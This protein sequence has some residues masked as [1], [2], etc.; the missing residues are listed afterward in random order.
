MTGIGLVLSGGGARGAYEVGVL[1]HI[2]DALPE[3][4]GRIRVITGASVGAVNAAFLASRGMT[5]AA[6]HELAAFWSRLSVDALI[7]LDRAG[8][9]SLVAA[10]GKRLIGREVDSPPVGLLNV[11][12]IANLVAE[13]TDWRNLRKVVRSRK[14][15]AVGVTAT[16]IS[17]GRSVFFVDHAQEVA[18]RWPRGDDAPAPERVALRA[19]HVLASAAIPLLFPPV[20]VNGRW[21]MDGGVRYNTPLAP[22]LGLGA[23]SLLIISVRADPA[24]SP[25]PPPGFSGFGQIV[26]KVLDSVF[27]DRIGY[28]LDR[29]RRI[30]DMVGA[31]ATAFGPE[32]IA[33]MHLE[34]SRISR[35]L[36][37][38]VPFSHVRPAK[39][40]GVLA[41]THLS[42]LKTGGPFSASRLL[43][44]LFQD[45]QGTTGDAASFLLFDAGYTNDLLEA[46]AR[47]AEACH[48][49]L[50][51][52]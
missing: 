2:A 30:N 14:L 6:V 41:A 25:P 39:D 4:L 24:A 21:F 35:P 34:L 36:Y 16:E 47:D 51:S 18:P 42:K 20:S 15:D 11:D 1:R 17:T 10:G 45:D 7:D 19:H 22:A 52:L 49:E 28:D 43:K 44:A 31:V 5:P 48:V 27:L 50:A 13:H 9:R 46:G 40:L 23:D 38:H 37:R 8:V 12:G 32:G 33:K 29:L 26:G 3:L